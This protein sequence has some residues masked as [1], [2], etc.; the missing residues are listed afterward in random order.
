M[1]LAAGP[2]ACE[3]SG[4]VLPAGSLRSKD[5]GFLSELLPATSA[6]GRLLPPAPQASSSHVPSCANILYRS[7]YSR[8]YK[9][10]FHVCGPHTHLLYRH[11]L[12]GG[13]ETFA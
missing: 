11:R 5:G 4:L 12:L 6:A 10:C 8:I 13:H 1:R 7:I 3:G 2:V 9:T